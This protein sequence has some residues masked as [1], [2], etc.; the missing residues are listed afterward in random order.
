MAT[1]CKKLHKPTSMW[2]HYSMLKATLR[3]YENLDI[4]QFFLVKG[5]LKQ[6]SIGYK[7]IRAEV[8]AEE[9]IQ[10]FI[11]EVDDKHYLHMK[12]SCF[13]C[14]YSTQPL[15]SFLICFRL[16]VFSESAEHAEQ[17]NL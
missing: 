6:K 15:I 11:M 17:T 16:S 13:V 1:T 8:F 10:K 2:A 4:A 3:T 7:S 9:Q 5:F 12:V 14:I